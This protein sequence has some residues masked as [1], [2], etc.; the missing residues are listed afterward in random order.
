MTETC[1][2][3]GHTWGVTTAPRTDVLCGPCARPTPSRQPAYYWWLRAHTGHWGAGWY[4]TVEWWDQ[5][6]SIAD[7]RHAA[8]IAARKPEEP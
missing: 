3:C 1:R 4:G 7:L 5:Q 2:A 6:T 8:D